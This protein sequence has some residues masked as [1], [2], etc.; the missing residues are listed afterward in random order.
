MPS[1]G[2]RIPPPS[3]N[4]GSAPSNQ[5][6]HRPPEKTAAT[7]KAKGPATPPPPTTTVTGHPPA[8]NQPLFVQDNLAKE[9][10]PAGKGPTI[11][12]GSRRS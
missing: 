5:Q 3:L 4:R 8:K 2:Q 10:K 11:P 9:T 7:S 1:K 6:V 12:H